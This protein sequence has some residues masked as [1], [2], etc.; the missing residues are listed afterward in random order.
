MAGLLA[1]R[2]RRKDFLE[3]DEAA[4]LHP[5]R[6]YFYRRNADNE[7]LLAACTEKLR[8]EPHDRRAR[9]VRAAALAKKGA[10]RRRPAHRRERRSPATPPTG[11]L[12]D[13]LRDYSV[14]VATDS[15]DQDAFY[16]RGNVHGK[17]R[18]RGQCAWRRGEGL[19]VERFAQLGDVDRA[20]ADY[21]R[22]LQLNP[23]H[24]KAAYARGT[25]QNLKGDFDEAIGSC[26]ATRRHARGGVV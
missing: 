8:Q 20:I 22:V 3:T 21:T 16:Q 18:T 26:T 19:R 9:F 4:N 11:R 1:C 12:E 24:A 7:A 13:A 23:D 15:A 25:C 6:A 17:V 14:L 5:H 2:R 10:R